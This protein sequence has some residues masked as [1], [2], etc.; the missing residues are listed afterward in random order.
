MPI[1]T[2]VIIIG[3]G[4][5]GCSVAYQLAKLGIK[6]TVLERAKFAA[7]ASGAT[8]GVVAPLWHVERS[9]EASF[10]LGMR[11]LD[12]FPTLAKDLVEAGIDPGFR[13]NG[14]LKLA[15]S[16]EEVDELKRN[17]AWQGELGLGVTWLDSESVIQREPEVNREVLG[18]V[19]SPKE[20][21]IEGQRYVEALAHAASRLGAQLHEGVEVTGLELQGHNVMG[22]RTNTGVYHSSHTVLAAGPWSGI[23]NRWLPEKL[24]VRPVKGQRILLRKAGFLPKCPVR[25]FQTYAVPWTDGAVLVASTREEGIF[26]EEPTAAGI[27]HLLSEAVTSFPVLKD[28]VFIGARAGVRPGTP[29]DVPIMGP[30][31]GWEGLSVIT[32]HDHV[33]IILSPGSGE[34]MANYI[35]TGNARPLEP[36]S[37]AR[38]P[39][40]GKVE[41]PLT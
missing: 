34:L 1:S 24:P 40:G 17:L 30:V 11:S 6:S 2:D 37:I 8:A 5:M 41:G 16:P 3:G 25:S 26:N 29:D 33:G 36:F 14:V 20:G 13:Q 19:F 23:A 10:A 31:P 32:G 39:A 15:F 28:A 27:S 7:G 22:V 35:D 38:F 9:S 12:R 21:H 18:G 4:V